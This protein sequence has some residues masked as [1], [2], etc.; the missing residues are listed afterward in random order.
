L[1]L[2]FLFGLARFNRL[3]EVADC[4]SSLV[5]V[6]D[7]V[8]TDDGSV[9]M[10]ALLKGF[11]NECGCS[12]TFEGVAGVIADC[13]SLLVA[14]EDVGVTDDGSV[15]MFALLKRFENECGNSSTFEGVAGV[16]A[17]CCSLL[18]AVEDVGVT[19]DGSVVMFAL[20]KGFENECGN[21][22]TFKG[23]AGFVFVTVADFSS[24]L[25][26]VSEHLAVGVFF[27][28]F[29]VAVLI[30]VFGKVTLLDFELDL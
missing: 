14:V 10:F 9:V 8:V 30:G 17:D 26:A 25:D 3:F 11:E 5:A 13:C 12:S 6:E 16:I 2:V 23:L 28:S 27:F 4:C 29:N 19:D 21:S 22:S 15:V 20:L 18:V 1:F 24:L 7:V